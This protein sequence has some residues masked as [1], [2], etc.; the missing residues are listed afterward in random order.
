MY[1]STT[2]NA[3]PATPA[4]VRAR[5][6]VMFAHASSDWIVTSASARLS[7]GPARLAWLRRLDRDV[8]L[9]AVVA[10][11]RAGRVEADPHLDD[12]RVRRRRGIDAEHVG[13]VDD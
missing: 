7:G 13:L 11:R 4:A 6:C 9:V 5:L 1:S 8:H 10:R 12:P 3:T 2:A